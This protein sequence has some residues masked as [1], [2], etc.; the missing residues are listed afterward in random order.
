MAIL[1][2]FLKIS[3]TYKMYILHSGQVRLIPG[4]QE[5][6]NIRKSINKLED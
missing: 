2:Q 3:T 5:C 1:L 4:M 6:F